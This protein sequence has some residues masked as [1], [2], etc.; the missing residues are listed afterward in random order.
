MSNDPS[1][2][3]DYINWLEKSTIDEYLNY[4]EYSDFKNT[5][6]IGGGNFGKVFRSNYKNSDTIFALKTFDN[7]KLTLKEIVNE[8][9]L[10]KRVD[11]HPNI[12][13][14]FGIT[15]IDSDVIY[16]TSKYLLVLEYAN[17]GTL[18]TYLDKH[19]NELDWNDKYQLAFQL[20]KA[21]E[22][23]HDL[24]IIHRDLH[25]NN[26]LI[27]Q[28]NVK[29]A[30][31]GL[32]RKISEASSNASIFGIIP[33]VD[34]KRLEK[35]NNTLYKLNKKSDIYSIGVLMWQISS[36]CKPFYT[37][38]YDATLALGI[39][40]GRR[41]KIVEGTPQKYS[42]LYKECWKH[43]HDK[44]PDIDKIASTLKTIISPETSNIKED[45]L[46]IIAII[47]DK[48]NPELSENID[49]NC[50]LAIGDISSS[51]LNIMNSENSSSNAAFKNDKNEFE[52][53]KKLANEDYVDAQYKLGNCY[54]EGIGTEINKAKAFEFYKIAADKG[55]NDAQYKLSFLYKSG[56][57]VEK[58]L[59][60]AF[61]LIKKLAEKKYLD[62][63]YQLG[64]Y[65]DKG[66]GTE[67]NKEKAYELYRI[68]AEEGNYDALYNISLLYELG[69]GVD[70]DERKAFNIL[71]KLSKKEYLDAQF[72]LGYF[73]EKGIGTKVDI[74]MSY[75]L[76][77]M[78][79]E[80]KKEIGKSD[81]QYRLSLL[82]K[83]SERIRPD[84]ITDIDISKKPT[85]AK[86]NK[87][88]LIVVIL[89]VLYLTSFTFGIYDGIVKDIEGD[90]AIDE[91]GVVL[92]NLA[93]YYVKKDAYKA[94]SYYKKSAE[95]GYSNAQ[96]R[97]GECYSSGTGTSIN[98]GKAFELYKVATDKGNHDAQYNLGELYELGEGISK[99][100][101]KAFE[102][103]KELAEK[104][105][106]NAQYRL[107]YYYEK[108]IGT[109][110]NMSEACE[111]YQ[112][113]ADNGNVEVLKSLDNLI[114]K[115]QC[116]LR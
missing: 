2:S 53:I 108:G 39:L 75:H 49:L 66:F 34:P 116:H 40:G 38:D 46:P 55:N 54:D 69:E 115:K 79:L 27:H 100:E 3:N 110:I 47:G 14:F 51:Q 87:T 4:Y 96:F 58:N 114:S 62:T 94:F 33:Y 74:A 77:K 41:E 103:I 93:Q 98:K 56:E 72:L 60:E 11:F 9:K 73:Y 21:V 99:D 85:T 48:S 5:Q 31:F 106:S 32:S 102:L 45:H 92:Y 50:D 105:Y 52:L 63:Q 13:R 18:E 42:N 12:L 59:K 37:E 15:K 71:N 78:V 29:L 91:Y 84:E 65:Y 43:E 7:C 10:Q 1:E 23:M 80:K 36:G 76:Y 61:D 67:V 109:D 101:E 97:L 111:L 57:G 88:L 95:E 68:A 44:R 113:A 89:I 6:L 22:C 70:K 17:S 107:G 82:Y 20:V 104:G 112:T 26:I 8:I 64:T 30:D 16:Q 25:A 19:F 83:L 86:V 35:N 24:D 81:A 90:H 28:K